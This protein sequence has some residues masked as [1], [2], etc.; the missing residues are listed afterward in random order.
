MAPVLMPSPHPRTRVAA[1]ESEVSGRA[2]LEAERTAALTPTTSHAVGR[3]LPHL[4][5]MGDA[6]E[7]MEMDNTASFWAVRVAS[8]PTSLWAARAAV[9]IPTA[10][11][12]D[13]HLGIPMGHS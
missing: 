3:E 12:T 7:A 2:L 4:T 11:D 1:W 6:I 10:C 13:G 9:G 5:G 8:Y